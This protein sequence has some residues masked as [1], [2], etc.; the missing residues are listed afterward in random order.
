[1]HIGLVSKIVDFGPEEG[2]AASD[3]NETVP[4]LSFHPA[5]PS[6]SKAGPRIDVDRISQYHLLSLVVIGH[7]SR[8][9]DASGKVPSPSSVARSPR[10]EGEKNVVVVDGRGTKF[11]S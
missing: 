10:D 5:V 9:I 7:M 2:N 8:G 1:L 6:D 3:L 11:H 4:F